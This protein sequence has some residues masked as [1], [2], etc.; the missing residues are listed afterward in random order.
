MQVHDY[1]SCEYPRPWEQPPGLRT[2]LDCAPVP[3]AQQ[4][5]LQDATLIAQAAKVRVVRP[6]ESAVPQSAQVVGL[7]CFCFPQM[8]PLPNHVCALRVALDAPFR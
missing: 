5:A 4:F 7:L 1:L 8:T 6:Q 2:L 3:F